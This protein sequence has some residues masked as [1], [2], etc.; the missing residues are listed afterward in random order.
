MIN[1]LLGCLNY[2]IASFIIKETDNLSIFLKYL[3]YIVGTISIIFG[4]LNLIRK[5]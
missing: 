3:N 2:F 5:L 1:I 4:F